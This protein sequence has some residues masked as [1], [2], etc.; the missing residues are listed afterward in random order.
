MY[1]LAFLLSYIHAIPVAGRASEQYQTQWGT[2]L[3]GQS[4]KIAQLRGAFKM[5]VA[6]AQSANTKRRI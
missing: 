6:A 5:I 2:Y 3:F 4:A 1:L